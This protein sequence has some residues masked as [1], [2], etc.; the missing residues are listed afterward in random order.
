MAELLVADATRRGLVN[1]RAV[2]L[3]TVVVRPGKRAHPIL[4][5]LGINRKQR[6]HLRKQ[7]LR[8][9]ILVGFS[10]CSFLTITLLL[11]A[12]RKESIHTSFYKAGTEV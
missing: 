12:L 9:L 2:R 3:P 8:L 1:G 10:A 6:E 5:S 4:A 7:A 11:S